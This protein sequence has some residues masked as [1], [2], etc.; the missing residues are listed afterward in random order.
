ML[1]SFAI[2]TY[3]RASELRQCLESIVSDPGDQ[4]E[5][6][7]SD[8]A[9]PDKTA[10]VLREFSR[11]PAVRVLTST[12]NMG[13]ERNMLRVLEESRGDY[14]FCL[15]DDDYLVPGA[16]DAL[17]NA[18]EAHPGTAVASSPLTLLNA[19]SG[20]TR[21]ESFGIRSGL[22]QA[23]AEALE[24]FFWRFHVWSGTVVRRDLLDLDAFRA[25]IGR[26]LYSIMV[27][28]SAAAKKAQAFFLPTPLVVHRVG[29]VTHWEYPDDMMLNGLTRLIDGLC[30]DLPDGP[31][32]AERL[33]KRRVPNLISPLVLMRKRSFRAFL[34]Q[35][36][37]L[38]AVDV[39]RSSALFWVYAVAVGVLG[40]DTTAWG[41]RLLRAVAAKPSAWRRRLPR[42]LAANERG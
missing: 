17:L 34:R 42:C 25:E 21:V 12:A 37:L 35:V 2:P 28:G 3:S 18:L 22:Y 8:N 31:R 40:A 4:Y 14:V 27:L 36:R 1:I 11:H 20:K 9:S 6:V 13:A 38:A 10:E 7:V 29:N 39:F 41:G 15:S 19:I 5:I 33:L 16:L 24:N 23:G 26:H 30:K 32:V